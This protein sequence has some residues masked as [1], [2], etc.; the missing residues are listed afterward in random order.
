MKYSPREIREFL[1]QANSD[2][3]NPKYKPT[4]L[5]TDYA[6]SITIGLE[7]KAEHDEL[8]DMLDT[9]YAGRR[10]SPQN[11]ISIKALLAKPEQK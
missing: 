9:C 10:L 2:L 3:G 11:H 8:V 1:K 4:D 7:L 5:V 6:K